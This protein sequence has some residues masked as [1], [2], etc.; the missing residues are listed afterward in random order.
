[1]YFFSGVNMTKRSIEFDVK[2][3]DF[4]FS[5][6]VLLRGTFGQPSGFTKVQFQHFI[7]LLS[8]NLINTRERK[9]KFHFRLVMRPDIGE[10]NFDGEC[11]LVSPQ[12][13]KINFV[14]KAIPKP[15]RIFIDNFIL[16]YSYYH[17]EKFA[18]QEN[19]PFPPA[20]ELLKR[21]GIN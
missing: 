19:F 1:M 8:Y 10:I 16:K 4:K 15:L 9:I 12:Q 14:I 7:D 13:N 6:E 17:A 2:I 3:K 18:K 21:F 11:V 20:Q 5:D